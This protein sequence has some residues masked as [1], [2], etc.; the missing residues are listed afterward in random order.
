MPMFDKWEWETDAEVAYYD[1]YREI[2]RGIWTMRDGTKIDVEDMSNR[3]LNNAIKM[4]ERKQNPTD[5]NEL[6]LSRLRQERT[7]RIREKFWEDA[8]NSLSYEDYRN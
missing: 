5:F 1:M 2:Q 7:R 6:W 8:L 3:H 4:L